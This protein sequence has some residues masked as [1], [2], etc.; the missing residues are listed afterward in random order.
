MKILKSKK[1][2][3]KK[4]K[5]GRLASNRTQGRENID[6]KR[7]AT[8]TKNIRTAAHAKTA[9]RK[10]EP[11]ENAEKPIG[12]ATKGKKEENKMSIYRNDKNEGSRQG[13]NQA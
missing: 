1:P 13:S 10:T 11:E 5:E 2:G 7:K 4:G 6:W 3:G 9:Q 12:K 8:F